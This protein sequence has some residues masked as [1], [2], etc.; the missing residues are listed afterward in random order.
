MDIYAGM[1]RG[2]FRKSVKWNKKGFDTESFRNVRCEFGVRRG[3]VAGC[4]ALC[5]G[6][7]VAWVHA[8]HEQRRE[9]SIQCM[10]PF[11]KLHTYSNQAPRNRKRVLA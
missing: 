1:V 4:V 7:R 6:W 5:C 8:D 2:G 9:D 11:V 10:A 3:S